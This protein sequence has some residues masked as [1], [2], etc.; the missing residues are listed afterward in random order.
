MI[1]VHTLTDGGQTDVEIAR[2]LVDYLAGAQRTVE[3]ALYDVRLTGEAG[4]L[5]RAALEDLPRR[6]VE[7][8]LVYNFEERDR[9]PVPPPPKTEPELIESLPFATRSVPGVPDLMH[10]KYVVRDRSSVWTGSTNWT[11][12][13]WTREENLIAVAASPALAERF[14][15]DFEQLWELRDVEKTGLVPTDPIDVG[16]VS[17]R[18][19]FCPKRGEKVAHRIAKAIGGAQRRIRIASPVITS[20]PILGTLAEVASDGR[21]DVAGVVDVT[22]INEVLHQWRENGN[23]TWK[24]PALRASLTR[25]PFS[26]QALDAVRARLRP[27]LHAREGDDRRRRRLHRQ[28]QPLALGRAE[29]GERPRDRRPRARRAPGRVRGRGAG[30]LPRGRVRRR[31]ASR[32]DR[33]RAQSE[34]SSSRST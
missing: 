26:G 5:I 2:R 18:T 4:D 33:W 24:A 25:A 31:I 13:S 21:V 12:D 29:R 28:L 32:A 9:P 6:G 1:D 30:A 8:R 16:G 20:G 34:T 14:L 15:T 23:S 27:R 19:W 17:V 11:N 3:L 10:H 7:A 22:Q